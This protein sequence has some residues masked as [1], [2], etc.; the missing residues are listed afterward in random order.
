MVSE[1]SW[2]VEHLGPRQDRSSFDGGVPA[3][4]DFLKKYA[5]QNEE[6]DFSR[7]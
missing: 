5:R 6:I 1:F 7:T 4:D 2:V 3:L